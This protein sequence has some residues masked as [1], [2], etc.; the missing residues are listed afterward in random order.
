MVYNCRQHILQ[1]VFPA[2]E[3]CLSK[4]SCV[5]VS[6]RN[7]PIWAPISWSSSIKPDKAW[8]PAQGL[9][10][11]WL[12]SSWLLPSNPTLAT[13]HAWSSETVCSPLN[14]THFQT[15]L[16]VSFGSWPS[17]RGLFTLK[18][19]SLYS[20][21]L[22]G[23]GWDKMTGTIAGKAIGRWDSGPDHIIGVL[24]L[25]LKL[26]LLLFGILQMS[27]I[28][29]G[30]TWWVPWDCCWGESWHI[31]EII[32]TVTLC[33]DGHSAFEL[34][35]PYQYFRPYLSSA[36]SRPSP[37]QQSTRSCSIAQTYWLSK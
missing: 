37:N 34:Q 2:A 7:V 15:L 6:A 27:V 17:S 35:F 20:P 30:N 19:S 5:D 12:T 31:V 14:C 13:G 29:M 11:P 23:S 1:L 18:D 32:Y 33:L 36:S 22:C 8:I 16:A 3:A 28:A 9:S 26:W 4:C 21:I 24:S 10:D 25:P